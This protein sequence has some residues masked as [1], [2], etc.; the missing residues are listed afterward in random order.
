MKLEHGDPQ[1]CSPGNSNMSGEYLLN[2]NG[3]LSPVHS[4]HHG[5]SGGGGWGWWRPVRGRFYPTLDSGWRRRRIV[6]QLDLGPKRR[7]RT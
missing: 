7:F 5:P 2:N 4:G 6:D 1:G 3:M